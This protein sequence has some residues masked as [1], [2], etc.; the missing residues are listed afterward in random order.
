MLE[1]MDMND[2]ELLGSYWTLAGAVHP[3]SETE[4]SPFD[5]RDRVAAAAKAGFKG[6][7]IKETDLEYILQ[8]RSLK[9]MKHIIEDHGMT[10]VELEFLADW[11][12][13]GEKKRKSDKTKLMLLKAAEALEARHIKAGDFDNQVTPMPKLIQSFAAL[14]KDAADFGTHFQGRGGRNPRGDEAFARA[15]HADVRPGAV[16]PARK[17]IDQL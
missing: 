14:C 9:D 16:R 15:R 12:L 3:H 13:D 8:R 7:G 1:E 5:F 10:H 11:F 2:V 17:G 6:I 4:Y